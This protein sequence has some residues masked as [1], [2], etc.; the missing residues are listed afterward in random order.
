MVLASLFSSLL[1]FWC[2]LSFW[3][4]LYT[5]VCVTLE[6]T[7]LLSCPQSSK[8]NASQIK[9]ICTL[10][11]PPRPRPCKPPQR[12]LSMINPAANAKSASV[13]KT[14]STTRPEDAQA[15]LTQTPHIIIAPVLEIPHF[16]GASGSASSTFLPSRMLAMTR[17]PMSGQRTWSIP[18]ALTHSHELAHWAVSWI[19]ERVSWIVDNMV[20][21]SVKHSVRPDFPRGMY[22]GGA[23]QGVFRRG[24]TCGV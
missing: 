4:Y 17:R 20:L 18:P 5:V 19:E 13:N 24:Y 9:Q 16:A 11:T 2:R 8:L 10:Q 23:H 3:M 15:I 21:K 22:V 1:M 12:C 7:F 6:P 14:S